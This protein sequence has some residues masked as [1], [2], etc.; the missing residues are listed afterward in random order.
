MRILGAPPALALLTLGLLL[1]VGSICPVFGQLRPEPLVD[2][3]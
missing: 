2:G 1:F 3:G